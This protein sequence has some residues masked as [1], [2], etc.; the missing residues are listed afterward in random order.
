MS[1]RYRRVSLR[2]WGDARFRA[3]TRAEP[4]A[5]TLWFY[6]LTGPETTNVPG[7]FSATEGGIADALGWDLKPFR[8]RFAELV[9]SGMAQADWE[10]RV[11]WLPNAI[12]HNEPANQKQVKGWLK[13]IADLPDSPLKNQAV[14]ALFRHLEGLDGRREKGKQPLAE[15]LRRLADA[16]SQAEPH[17]VSDAACNQDQDQEAGSGSMIRRKRTNTPVELKQLDRPG[18]Q[19]IANSF[20]N[21]PADVLTVFEYYRRRHPRAH[22]RPNAK[23]KAWKAICARMK[24]GYTVEDLCKAIDGMHLTPHNLGEN[25]RK[26]KYLALEL[27]M[28]DSG[29]VARFIEAADDPGLKTVGVRHRTGYH[30]GSRPEEFVDGEVAL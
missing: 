24:D 19:A 13:T 12:K 15:P 22:P 9:S 8:E 29:Q 30:P 16:A 26:T 5:Q 17:T 18:E 25:D 1:H 6:V 27:C 14:V 11:V 20:A 3:L 28:R 7:L 10:A 2:V 21:A 4:N 23:D